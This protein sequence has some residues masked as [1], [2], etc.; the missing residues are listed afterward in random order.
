MVGMRAGKRKHPEDAFLKILTE[1]QA[2]DLGQY[3]ASI[4]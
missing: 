3:F 1:K 2:V 4:P